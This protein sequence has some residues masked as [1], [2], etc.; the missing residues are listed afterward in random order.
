MS[1]KGWLESLTGGENERNMHTLEDN[2]KTDV[3]K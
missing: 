2:I 1:R 3:R